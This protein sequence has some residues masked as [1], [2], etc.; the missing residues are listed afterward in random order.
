MRPAM[1]CSRCLFT[2]HHE[3][4]LAAHEYSE[5][6]LL[7]FEDTFRIFACMEHWSFLRKKMPLPS[8]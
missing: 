3:A 5:I 6:K 2:L 7:F 8:A 1:R 4:S